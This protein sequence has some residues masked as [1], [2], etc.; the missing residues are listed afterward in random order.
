[1]DGL[2]EQD[3]ALPVVRF[4]SKF[5]SKNESGRSVNLLED[6]DFS[7]TTDKVSA[8]CEMDVNLNG[9]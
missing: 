5:C 3:L 4:T 7:W 1:M 9:E 8:R 6:Q 2:L